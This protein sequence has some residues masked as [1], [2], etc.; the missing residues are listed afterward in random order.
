MNLTTSFISAVL[1]RYLPAC[2]RNS[3]LPRKIGCQIPT[4]GLPLPGGHRTGGV[5]V[6]AA[7]E[8][9]YTVTSVLIHPLR[10]ILGKPTT[11]L[12]RAG[13]QVVEAVDRNAGS[14]ARLGE[15]A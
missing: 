3:G 2:E 6:F 8:A 13:A 15:Q 1:A 9:F 10:C 11:P 14:S 12:C 5:T 7:R 4:M